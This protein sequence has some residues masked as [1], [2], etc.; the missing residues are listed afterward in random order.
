M[1]KDKKPSESID[2]FIKQLDEDV[3]EEGNSTVDVFWDA[4]TRCREVQG[5]EQEFWR[6]FEQEKTLE[7]TK[8][9]VIK[10]REKKFQNFKEDSKLG[11]LPKLVTF[12]FEGTN[13]NWFRFL[14]TFKT[15]I[16]K[17]DH[18]SLVTNNTYLMEFKLRHVYK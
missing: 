12:K 18:R 2:A 13:L 7:E 15:E 17:G 8:M 4:K 14:T 9:E 11:K 10:Q 5:Q 1:I 16:D 3:S 6:R